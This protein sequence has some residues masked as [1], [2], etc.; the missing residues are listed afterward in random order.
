MFIRKKEEANIRKFFMDDVDKLLEKY[1]PGEPK[2]KPDVL[3]QIKEIEKDRA[4]MTEEMLAKNSQ[5]TMQQPGQPP[6]ALSPA[7]VVELIKNQQIQMENLSQTAQQLDNMNK[8]LQK[9]LFEK[10]Q[11]IMKLNTELKMLRI[12][13]SNAPSM[14]DP[15]FNS[16]SM[17]DPVF[18]APPVTD[19]SVPTFKITDPT[20]L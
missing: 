20:L 3:K 17:I 16:P 1:E 19:K 10:Q 9:L 13:S 15:I 4:R 2:M 18:S 5:I 8:Q 6:V 7:Q 11:E 14:I 12:A